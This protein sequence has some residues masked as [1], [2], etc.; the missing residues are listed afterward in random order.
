MLRA[1][2]TGMWSVRGVTTNPYRVGIT[3][4]LDSRYC[5]QKGSTWHEELSP[6]NPST[7]KPKATEARDLSRFMAIYGQL[8]PCNKIVI[9]ITSH[10][11]RCLGLMHSLH[12]LPARSF[13]KCNTWPKALVISSYFSIVDDHRNTSCGRYRSSTVRSHRKIFCQGVL[14]HWHRFFGL[15]DY[16]KG[17]IQC[18]S[19]TCRRR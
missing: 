2:S 10:Q 3:Q 9:K 6:S 19:L 5:D 1:I 16:S 8:T 12:V 17:S 11:T 18:R 15:R 13:S 4:K 7:R 14:R